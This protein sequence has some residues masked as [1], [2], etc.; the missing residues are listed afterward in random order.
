MA[1]PFTHLFQMGNESGDLAVHSPLEAFENLVGLLVGD[2]QRRLLLG[3]GRASG[4]GGDVS[5]CSKGG[6]TLADL[7]QALMFPL[8]S[9]CQAS[10]I[11]P[12]ISKD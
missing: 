3:G 8:C 2:R 1:Q 6:S 4:P 12:N 11:S 5:H 9:W 10:K 7:V